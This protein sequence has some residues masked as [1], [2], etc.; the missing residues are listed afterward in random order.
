MAHSCRFSIGG[1]SHERNKRSLRRPMGHHPH[2][3]PW[4]SPS[5]IV[6]TPWARCSDPRIDLAADAPPGVRLQIQPPPPRAA[7]HSPPERVRNPGARQPTSRPTTHEAHEQEWGEA[8]A[9]RKGGVRRRIRH[10]PAPRR[11]DTSPSGRECSVFR[12]A[13]RE[14]RVGE[15]L[16]TGGRD[17]LGRQRPACMSERTC[18][19]ITR[20][21]RGRAS[22]AARLRHLCFRGHE[23][24]RPGA[25]GAGTA[26][27]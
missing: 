12:N 21:A 1:R 7:T 18:H 4:P 16:Q 2:H 27:T 17:R 25:A 9:A 15:Q 10:R 24:V 23:R 14:C 11:A 13:S 22:L 6:M 19:A 8:R 20:G 26:V 3:A 5:C